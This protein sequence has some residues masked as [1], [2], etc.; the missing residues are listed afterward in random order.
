M[1]NFTITVE[2]P[3]LDRLCDLL[4]QKVETL[5]AQVAPEAVAPVVGEA[6]HHSEPQPAQ[7]P[8][9]PETP[10]A[11]PSPAAPAA[12]APAPAIQTTAPSVTLEAVMRAAAGLRDAGKLPQV[13][14]LF[15]EF[16]I[17]KLSD[18]KPDQLPGFAA[19]LR[20]LGARIG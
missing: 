15:P 6:I 18:L 9:K 4:A 12:P 1:S 8:D 17:Q 14:A 11:T 7:Q 2:I 10:P 13:T 19:K 5:T 20:E 16:G 3:A